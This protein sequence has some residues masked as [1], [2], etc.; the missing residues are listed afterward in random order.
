[1]R[2][3]LND[4]IYIPKNANKEL[5]SELFYGFTGNDEICKLTEGENELCIVSGKYEKAQTEDASYV[6]NISENGFYIEGKDFESLMRAFVTFMT[7]I[8]FAD[9]K[10][11]VECMLIKENPAMDF[12]C[13]H[14]CVFPETDYDFLKKCMRT[15]AVMKCTHIVLEFW[16][17]LKFDFMKELAWDCAFTKEQ[18]R[19]LVKEANDLGV[20]IIPMFNHL[21]H[22]SSSRSC[23]GKH[24]VL[25]QNPSLEYL[26]ES[27]GWRWN[28]ESDKVKEVLRNVRKELIELCGKGKYFHMG[29]DEAYSF[30]NVEDYAQSELDMVDFFNEVQQELDAYGRR[31]IIWSDLLITKRVYENEHDTSSVSDRYGRRKVDDDATERALAK[32]NKNILIADWH[33][34]I[35]T[36]PWQTAKY[37]KD[38]GFDVVCCP[39][40]NSIENVEAAIKTAHTEQLFGVMHTTWN[41]IDGG[42]P[43][44]VYALDACWSGDCEKFSYIQGVRLLAANIQR[45]VLP[46]GGNYE[47]SGWAK[48]QVNQQTW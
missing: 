20:E 37:F 40:D 30:K 35:K 10:P 8:E 23:H 33:Y 22:A 39:W 29:C 38:R 28:I 9:E 19:P 14:L 36:Y 21:G 44:M 16:G 1:M 11:S 5:L 18:I 31:A 48:Y 17:M 27:Y 3:Y 15:C 34:D 4:T 2:N 6:I 32:L 46:S 25:D 41:S 47:K 13:V 7:K 42:F 24:V 26:F 12:R 45:K 43:H